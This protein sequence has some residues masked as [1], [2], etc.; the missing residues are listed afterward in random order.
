[1]DKGCLA[2]C[3]PPAND[4][5]AT[6]KADDDQYDGCIL[7]GMEVA[8]L[9]DP[10]MGQ[11]LKAQAVNESDIVPVI[12]TQNQCGGQNCGIWAISAG[13]V[14]GDSPPGPCGVSAA[15]PSPGSGGMDYSHSYGIFQSTPACEGT[16]I[17]PLPAGET[18]TDTG[19]ADLI[20]F[21]T[22]VHFYCETATSQGVTRGDGVT[23]KGAINAVQDKTSPY[24]ATSV[25]NPA[26]QLFVYITYSWK[27]N[28]EQANA[29]ATGCTIYQQWYLSLA[30][31][32]TG[33]PTNSCTLSGSGLKYVQG[34]E[35][36]YKDLYGMAWPYPGP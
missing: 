16:F 22:Q 14:S 15:D 7:A 6:G 32:L 26:Y 3:S 33:N 21:G 23:V 25:F 31:W 34:A 8:G 27:Y 2:D 35:S 28:F 5:I 36:N 11:L 13:A 29:M 1:M 9:T 4:P 20:P 18:C 12:T 17:Q 30:Y 24:Y 10:W 19:T